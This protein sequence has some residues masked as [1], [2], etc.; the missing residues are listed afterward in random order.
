MVQVQF[1]LWDRLEQA[2]STALAY[3]LTIA[4]G[5]FLWPGYVLQAMALIFLVHVVWFCF[6]P[7]FPEER[8]WSR[9]LTIAAAFSA[10]MTGYGIARGWMVGDYLLWQTTLAAIVVLIAMDGCGSSALHKTTISHWLQKGDYESLFQPV[11]DPALCTNC[12][13]CVLVCP[14]DVFAAKRSD[15]KKVVS[16]K[17]KDC[18]ECMA[19]VKQ[20]HDDAILNR[21]GEYKGDVKSIPNLHHLMTRD[22]SYLRAEDR[23][24]GHPTVLHNGLPV[25]AAAACTRATAV[26]EEG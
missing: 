14:R 5:L 19:C 16:T 17:P 25:I 4:V 12:M 15:P 11:I 8:R 2:L 1:G 24:I 13:A 7:L 20:C 18:I 9:T 23:W 6:L 3:C 10:V 21:S 26:K 22:W